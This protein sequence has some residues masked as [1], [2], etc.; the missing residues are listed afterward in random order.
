MTRHIEPHKYSKPT[1]WLRQRLPA[2]FDDG[3]SP[4]QI[5]ARL[6]FEKAQTVVSH[7]WVYRFLIKDKQTGGTFFNNLIYLEIFTPIIKLRVIQIMLFVKQSHRMKRMLGVAA[8]TAGAPVKSSPIP[9]S[10]RQILV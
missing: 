4:K 1:M 10:K 3:M 2:W 6:R 8:R 7:E 5:L 9:L